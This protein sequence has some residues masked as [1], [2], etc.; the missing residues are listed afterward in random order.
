MPSRRSSSRSERSSCFAVVSSRNAAN[1]S[2]EPAIHS[3]RLRGPC[4]TPYLPAFADHVPVHRQNSITNVIES[5][6]QL[7][8]VFL[9]QDD[10]LII[11]NSDDFEPGRAPK[12]HGTNPC[13]PPNEPAPVFR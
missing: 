8:P 13:L 6:R 12:W 9:P 7:G 5:Q 11:G 3:P 4:T 2:V 1:I 10:V